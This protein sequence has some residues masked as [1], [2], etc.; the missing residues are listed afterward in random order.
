MLESFK[1]FLG[2]CR[3]VAVRGFKNG[4]AWGR[5]QLLIGVLFAVLILFFQIKLGVIKRAEANAVEWALFYP[6]LILLGAFVLFHIGRAVWQ[7]D[8]EH[9][10][11]MPAPTDLK[12]RAERI[13]KFKLEGL[14]LNDSGFNDEGWLKR[15]DVWADETRAFLETCSQSA[16]GVWDDTTGLVNSMFLGV[17]NNHQQQYGLLQRRLQNLSKIQDKPDVYLS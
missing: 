9:R 4:S 2:Y 13:A 8:R 1:D 17:P 10:K 14:A 3:R 16:V 7:L 15:V 6:Y 11:V 12:S 5:D